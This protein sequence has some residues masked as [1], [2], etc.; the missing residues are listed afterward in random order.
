MGAASREFLLMREEETTGQMYVP[1]LPKKEIKEK[2]KEDVAKIVEGGEVELANAL[3]DS[4]RISEYLSTFVSELKPHITED[5][6][7][8]E[9]DLKGAKISFR[10]TGDRLDY[11]QDEVYSNLKQAL[12][13]REALLKLAYKSKE[14]LFD[15][16]G[17][18]V[19]KVG[20]K[21]VSKQTVVITY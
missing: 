8:K 21:T 9:Y 2:A 6:F 7:G 19:P 17:V 3:V 12:K 18:E 13:E 10:G 4:A 16:E 5:E 1:A 14:M 15:S 20:I 11:D